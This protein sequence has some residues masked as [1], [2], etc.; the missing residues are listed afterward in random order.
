[1]SRGFLFPSS[2]ITCRVCSFELGAESEELR[3]RIAELRGRGA[4][5][6]AA[7]LA[8]RLLRGGAEKRRGD[9]KV[10]RK[11]LRAAM[12]LDVNVRRRVGELRDH[13]L[14]LHCLVPSGQCLNAAVCEAVLGLRSCPFGVLVRHDILHCPTLSHEPDRHTEPCMVYLPNAT[15]AACSGM[16]PSS[17]FSMALPAT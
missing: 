12:K 2:R 16:F 3:L 15:S 14:G 10:L 6:A 9:G 1:M 17:L 5:S 13:L 4:L 8:P 11:R 7:T